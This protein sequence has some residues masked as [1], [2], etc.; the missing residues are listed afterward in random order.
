MAQL[1]ALLRN[2]AA[3]GPSPAELLDQADRFFRDSGITSHFATLVCTRATPDGRIDICN[4]GHCPPIIAGVRG[5]EMVDGGG[6]P[7][8]LGAGGYEV[9]SRSLSGGEMMVLYS[10]GLTETFN[11]AG[12]PY[13][14]ERLQEALRRHADQAPAQLAAACLAD[15]AEF[16]GGEPRHDDLSL[17]VVRRT[18]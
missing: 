3:T 15:L 7:V 16:Q 11:E 10:D 4:A 17:M 1:N 14:V 2:L 12:L 8:G 13:G 6:F 5:V 9:C 18:A